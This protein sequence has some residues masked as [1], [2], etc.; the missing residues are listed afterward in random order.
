MSMDSSASEQNKDSRPASGVGRRTGVGVAS[1]AF[2]A[3]PALITLTGFAKYAFEAHTH[4]WGEDM[5]ELGIQAVLVSPLA[6]IALILAFW[7]RG[8][9]WYCFAVALVYIIGMPLLVL[10]VG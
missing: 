5:L 2:G 7:A 10:L 3:L 1:I 8:M 9:R 4:A 6:I